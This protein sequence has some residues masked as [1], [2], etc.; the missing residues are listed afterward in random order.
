MENKDHLDDNPEISNLITLITQDYTYLTAHT[1]SNLLYNNNP[2]DPPN[3]PPNN[4]NSPNNPNNKGFYKQLSHT[5]INEYI[6]LEKN[7][8]LSSVHDLVAKYTK[9]NQNSLKNKEFFKTSSNP[10]LT[11]KCR[12]ITVWCIY[13]CVCVFCCVLICFDF[14]CLNMLSLMIYVVITFLITPI[15]LITMITMIAMI[16]LL[17]TLVTVITLVIFLM[18]TLMII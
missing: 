9:K 2:N 14:V 12:E 1:L 3:N 13:M 18:M 4:P 17:I 16:T 6:E 5:L 8:I 15:T 10:V 7:I 11:R